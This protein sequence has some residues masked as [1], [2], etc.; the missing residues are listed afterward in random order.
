MSSSSAAAAGGGA[1]YGLGIFVS[2]PTRTRAL[3]AA[4]RES[5]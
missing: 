3:G 4:D 5:S 1:L 2:A